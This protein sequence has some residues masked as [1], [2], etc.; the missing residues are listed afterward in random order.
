MALQRTCGLSAAQF[1]RFAG[2]C[3]AVQ[4][5][6][7]RRSPLNAVAL[8]ARSVLVAL[9]LLLVACD[10]TQ[11]RG[12]PTGPVVKVYVQANGTILVDGRISTLEE[13]KKILADLKAQDGAVS[14]S[15][16][17]PSAEPPPQAMEVMVAITEA[18]LPVLLRVSE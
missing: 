7:A 4:D 11:P 1:L 15:R 10:R 5:L 12:E 2:Y 17:N 9:S 3:P 13:L 14:Y 18:R 16:A 8:G 6:P